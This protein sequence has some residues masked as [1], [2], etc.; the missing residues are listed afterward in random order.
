MRAPMLL[1]E[2][3]LTSTRMRE[4][5]FRGFQ[6]ACGRWRRAPDLQREF[7]CTAHGG[8][9]HRRPRPRPCQKCRAVA[10]LPN[11]AEPFSEAVPRGETHWVHSVSTAS[12]QC[13]SGSYAQCIEARRGFYVPL[14]IVHTS[15]VRAPACSAASRRHKDYSGRLCAC[16]VRRWCRR[17]PAPCR[18]R[19]TPSA[20]R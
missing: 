4:L 9:G 1:I 16:E 13:S 11:V 19:V 2:S 18:R 17:S 6:R 12:L 5:C 8:D 7:P 14:Y 3:R 10:G 15:F 20:S